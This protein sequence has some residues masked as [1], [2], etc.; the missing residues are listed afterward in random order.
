MV[1]MRVDGE[2]R[3]TGGAHQVFSLP[4]GET[5][6]LPLGASLSPMSAID[7]SRAYLY[8]HHA[9]SSYVMIP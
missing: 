8:A 9:S 2:V 7:S 5:F 4:I 6:S 1:G 3:D